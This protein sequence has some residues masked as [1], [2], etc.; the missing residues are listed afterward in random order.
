MTHPLLTDDF[1]DT[2]FWWEAAPRQEV[3]DSRPP[4]QADVV[5]VGSGNVGLSAALTLA[6]GGREV[7]VLDA[8]AA[9][10]GGASRNAGYIGRTLW[11]K[12][13]ALKAK[14][15][16]EAAKTLTDEAEQAHDFVADLI[17]KEQ[18]ACHF[19]DNGRFIPAPSSA[20]YRKLENELEAMKR[21][22]VET[23]SWMLPRERQREEL[24][25]DLYHGGQVLCGT[26]Q[27]HPGLYHQ[28]L[29]D[30]VTSQGAKVL[31]FCPATD[32]SRDGDRFKVTT[33]KGTVMAQDVIVA[34]NGYTPKATPWLRR[35]VV[36][37][38]AYMMAT[39]PLSGDTMGRLFPNNRTMIDCRRNPYW[40]R[41][42]HDG[43][44]LLFGGQ[45]GM[46]KASLADK[47]LA[48]HGCMTQ[49]FPELGDTKVSHCWTGNVAFSFDM[50]PHMGQHDGVFY[51]MGFC[52]AG[53]PM[54][55]YM[56][57]KIAHKILGDGDASTPFD[58]LRFPSNP[59]YTGLPWFL[60]LIVGYF[61]YMD[62]KL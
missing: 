60:P 1:K 5:V 55:T 31:G 11:F 56:G 45:T 10:H 6:R 15:G 48:L 30:R 53:V 4:P 59:F 38:P 20:A 40:A 50:L 32:I 27:L 8:E 37:V 24:G 9:G 44:R 3:D 43:K 23:E 22:G 51:A 12:Y 16:V 61:N 57:D 33:P 41:P 17:E 25:S 19:V 21:D 52:A 29:L 7:L 49:V 28:G 46:R 2:P 58:D 36:P 62:R 39:E 54:G 26:G 14:L 47:A 34:T 13:G 42:S 18:I 35:R